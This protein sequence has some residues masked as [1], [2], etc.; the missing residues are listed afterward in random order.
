MEKL[1]WPVGEHKGST[2][3]E[4][5]WTNPGYIWWA[6][7]TDIHLDA[8]HCDDGMKERFLLLEQKSKRLKLKRT[9]K[10]GKKNKSKMGI[11]FGKPFNGMKLIS[12]IDL[13][14]EQCAKKYPYSIDPTFAV[15]EHVDDY[16]RK[17]GDIVVKV[18]KKEYFGSSDH[19]V[20]KEDAVSFFENSDNFFGSHV[21]G[22]RTEQLSSETTN[23]KSLTI[24][25]EKDIF[26][27]LLECS[28]RNNESV[29]EVIQKICEDHIKAIPDIAA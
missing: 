26:N 4:I 29:D 28:D 9:C 16:I 5:F 15:C 20:S 6:K 7:K 19:K 3:E 23:K 2:I 12:T 27:Y 10:C 14:C 18:L 17:T 11:T 13:V 1:V 25:V 8:N 21:D 24:K 22:I